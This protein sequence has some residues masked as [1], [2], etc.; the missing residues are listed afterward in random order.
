MEEIDVDLR[1]VG[2]PI[3]KDH[4]Y[5][6]RSHKSRSRWRRSSRLG[7]RRSDLIAP[8]VCSSMCIAKSKKSNKRCRKVT[9]MD[10]RYC[11]VH[12]ASEKQLLIYK[13]KRLHDLKLNGLGLYAYDPSLGKLDKDAGGF[14]KVGRKVVFKTDEEID[15]YAGERMTMQQHNDRYD[16]PDDMDTAAYAESG[17]NYVIDGIAAASAVSYANESL[18]IK[19]LMD[20]YKKRSKFEEKYEE[21]ASEDPKANATTQ[22]GRDKV[23]RMYAGKPIRQGQEILWHY[24][25]DY[26]GSLGM[27]RMVTGKDW[28]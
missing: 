4:L 22:E 7:T 10:Y 6:E 9:C 3:S 5:V 24:G 23:I 21:A 20:K 15:E 16:D 1:R 26:W 8:R 28:K 19:S 25:P 27:K 14:P 2:Y 18:D 12:L 13:S 17:T 11:P